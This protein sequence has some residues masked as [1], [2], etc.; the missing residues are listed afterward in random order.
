[1]GP[2]HQR[3]EAG[4][5]PRRRRRPEP[6]HLSQEPEQRRAAGGDAEHLPHHRL[7]PAPAVARPPQRVLELGRELVGTGVDDALEQGV[8]AREVVEDR[9]LAHAQL[10]GDGVER[11]RLETPGPERRQRGVE[12][13]LF[14]AHLPNGRQTGRDPGR[15]GRQAHRHHRHH[16]LPRHRAARA[17]AA[18]RPR[19][20]RSSCSCGPAGGRRSTQRAR[21][22]IFRND[23]FDRLRSELGGKPRFD[24]LIAGESRSSPATSAATDST[25]T[26]PA[27]RARRLRHRHPQRRDRRVRLAARLGGRGQPPRADSHRADPL[28]SLGVRP[29]L[30]A[31]STCYV[32][33]NRRGAAPEQLLSREPVLPR[34]RLARRGRRR[35]PG[36]RRRGGRQP[37][38]RSA[39][40]LPRR[41]PSRARCRRRALAR[42]ED[43][44]ASHAVGQGAHDRSRPRSRRRRSAGRTR[45]RTPRLSAN[46]RSPR[47][48]GDVPVSIVRPVDHRV[49]ARRAAAGLD[50]RLPH[51]RAGHHL[52]RPRAAPRVP[53][54]PRGDRGRHSR[55]PR[56]RRGVRGRGAR[57]VCTTARS[58]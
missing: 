39:A 21:R 56:R 48:R 43:R 13:S 22:E 4:G 18:H 6:G 20:A 44:A 8:L 27:R 38:P 36:P 37:R 9:L 32:A 42:G 31:V 57:P 28:Q 14:R 1:M 49:V 24:A 19:R 25:S 23:A 29:H 34:H 50:Q 30:V 47:S 26:T 58:T 5:Q 53:R 17:A 16:R 12:H 51:G 40:P 46:G 41:S 33:G 7:H 2:L 15:P 54:R 11:R 52:L 3:I 35:P 55:R 45:T 10:G